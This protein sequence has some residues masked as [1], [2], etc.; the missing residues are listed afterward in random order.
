MCAVRRVRRKLNII[1]WNNYLESMPFLRSS[2]MENLGIR[3]IDDSANHKRASIEVLDTLLEQHWLH[4]ILFIEQNALSESRLVTILS[5]K[6]NLV[7]T[8]S[9]SKSIVCTAVIVFF[10]GKYRAIF[11]N[12]ST[13]TRSDPSSAY[14]LNLR[15]LAMSGAVSIDLQQMVEAWMRAFHSLPNCRKET[16]PANTSTTLIKVLKAAYADKDTRHQPDDISSAVLFVNF[17]CRIVQASTGPD[18]IILDALAT[19]VKL[20]DRVKSSVSVPPRFLGPFAPPHLFES[21]RFPL[22]TYFSPTYRGMAC[23]TVT[24]ETLQQSRAIYNTFPDHLDKALSDEL[25]AH[26]TTLKSLIQSHNFEHIFT[27]HRL[28]RHFDLL[29]GDVV[30]GTKHTHPIYAWLAKPTPTDII[31]LDETHPHNI[32]VSPA[33]HITS[34]EFR[35]GKFNGFPDGLDR[36]LE[37]FISYIRVHK[38]ESV[39]GLQLIQE[40][41]RNMTEIAFSTCTVM[42][43]ESNT[44]TQ[45]IPTGWCATDGGVKNLSVYETHREVDGVHRRFNEGTPGNIEE[46]IDC[47]RNL[48]VLES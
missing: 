35:A 9:I 14:C 40:A 17:A 36:F 42:F 24:H 41:V 33:G 10:T 7:K 31:S 6:P 21:F 29:Q 45:S 34:Y 4:R 47:L 25:Q 27:I 48:G 3:D 12:R 23:L 13:T 8:P 1:E 39:L 18:D 37:E 30:Y 16:K 19:Y 46:A 44:T 22:T 43:E 5:R 15:T 20:Y 38:L 26:L 2:Y 11:E 28:H 32:C